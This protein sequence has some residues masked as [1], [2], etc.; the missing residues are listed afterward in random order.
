MTSHLNASD[1]HVVELGDGLRFRCSV[2]LVGG[3]STP[4]MLH[5][6]CETET[7]QYIGPVFAPVKNLDA[8]TSIVAEWWSARQRFAGR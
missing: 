7:T 1:T 4:A 8:L 6:I 2:E 3:L 5:W